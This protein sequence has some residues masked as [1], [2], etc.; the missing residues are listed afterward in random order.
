MK[1]KKIAAI[2]LGIFLVTGAAGNMAWAMEQDVPTETGYFP[3]EIVSRQVDGIERLE[4]TYHLTAEDDSAKI[5]TE[6]V[7]YQG[8]EYVFV[9]LLKNDQRKSDSKMHTEIVTL[10]SATNQL[11]KILK[12]LEPTLEIQTEDGYAGTV[13]L[14]PKSIEVEAAG[15][16]TNSYTVSATRIY[17]NLSDADTSLIPKSV[18][19]NGRTLTL[20]E[21]CWQPAATDYVDGYDLVMRYTAVAA[22]SGTAS[23]KS[24]TG[25]VVTAEYIGEVTKTTCE[26]ILYTAV[27]AS[28]EKAFLSDMPKGASVFFCILVILIGI[29][30]LGVLGKQ[31]E[32]YLNK[33]RG[34]EE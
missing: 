22:Y 26:D 31:Y 2:L 20:A 16:K 30:L 3:T 29:L 5:P 18:T 4:K 6:P 12:T 33:K 23:S 21:V 28:T 8:K 9:E 32:H 13:T 17:P 27:F 19:E 10:N 15:Y 1:M 25:Y 7:T 24:A 14:N 11:E 34:Y